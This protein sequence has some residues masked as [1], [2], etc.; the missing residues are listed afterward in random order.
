MEKDNIKNLQ[1]KLKETQSLLLSAARNLA[2]PAYGHSQ[3][4]TEEIDKL[5]EQCFEFLGIPK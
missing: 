3:Y 5:R 4:T 1:K 2:H